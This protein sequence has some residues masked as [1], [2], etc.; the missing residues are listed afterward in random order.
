MTTSGKIKGEVKLSEKV[1]NITNSPTLD[2]TSSLQDSVNE[3]KS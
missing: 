3:K 2:S 1:I